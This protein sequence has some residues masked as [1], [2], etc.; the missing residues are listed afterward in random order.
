MIYAQS[1]CKIKV[2]AQTCF[3]RLFSVNEVPALVFVMD[4]TGS[5][6]E[7]ITAA[8]SRAHSI[9]QSRASGPSQPR[10]F[11]LIPFH[12]PGDSY[13]Q[14]HLDSSNMT[15]TFALLCNFIKFFSF[16]L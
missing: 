4:T 2:W 7:E 5:M 3:H 12:D 16:K 6:F 15:Y 9:I 10:T 11:L 13:T 14:T 8:R 1:I